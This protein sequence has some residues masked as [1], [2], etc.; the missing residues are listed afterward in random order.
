MHAIL[1]CLPL[2]LPLIC[3][4]FAR[5][6]P[7]KP[8]NLHLLG[9]PHLND[10]DDG[11][12]IFKSVDIVVEYSQGGEPTM[13]KDHTVTVP[14]YITEVETKNTKTGSSTH[15][16]D[17]FASH[18]HS[19]GSTPTRS[20]HSH[21]PS[22]TK[23]TSQSSS[24][25]APPKASSTSSREPRASSKTEPIS[26]SSPR[27]TRPSA[28]SIAT[29][30]PVPATSITTEPPRVTLS[31]PAPTTSTPPPVPPTTITPPSATSTSTHDWAWATHGALPYHSGCRRGLSELE[32]ICV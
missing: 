2:T 17:S 1:L 19:S 6:A 10:P 25:R 18:T 15:F 27:T 5:A 13:Y 24:S 22:S 11:A 29:S 30:S 26:S 21:E 28:S 16:S 9:R 23:A 32:L 4:P 20:P 3:V 31:P 7:Y 12:V 8:P 14:T